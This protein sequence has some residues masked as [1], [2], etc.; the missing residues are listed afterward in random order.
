MAVDCITCKNYR[1]SLCDNCEFGG[2][3]LENHYE[4]ASPAEI[5][6]RSLENLREREKSLGCEI[7]LL[8][9]EEKFIAALRMAKELVILSPQKPYPYVPRAEYLVFCAGE[10]LLKATNSYLFCEIHCPIPSELSGKNIVYLEDK[11]I[12]LYPTRS[13]PWEKHTIDTL[14]NLN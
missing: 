13:V 8:E 10:D 14:C 11:M 1:S 6:K 4:L 3:I 9:P 2:R 7:C 5:E 12:G